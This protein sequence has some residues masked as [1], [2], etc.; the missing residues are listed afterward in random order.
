MQLKVVENHDG[1]GI[2]PTFKKG[3][4]VQEPT[5]CSHYAHWVSV[6]IDGH[7][8]YISEDY[9]DG[10][11]L[12]CDY[13]PTEL[14]TKKGEKVQLLL[15]VYEWALVKNELGAVGWLPFAKLTSCQA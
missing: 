3:T 11:L 4:L 2:F 13:N 14:I 1:E 12:N 7:S 10:E 5:P 15:A 8:T 6:T 9:I